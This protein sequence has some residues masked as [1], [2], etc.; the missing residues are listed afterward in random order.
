MHGGASTRLNLHEHSEKMYSCVKQVNYCPSNLVTSLSISLTHL[1]MCGVGSIVHLKVQFPTPCAQLAALLLL[2]RLEELTGGTHL[3]PKHGDQI[4]H[5]YAR[6]LSKIMMIR[7][8]TG[9]PC[10]VVKSVL[11]CSMF[12][13]LIFLIF[14]SLHGTNKLQFHILFTGTY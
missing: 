9:M 8:D 6:L 3:D 12:I 14:F 1:G 4:P 13:G 7:F 2:H 11:W 5:C 10:F